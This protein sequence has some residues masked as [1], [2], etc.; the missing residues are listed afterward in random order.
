VR[1]S[2]LSLVARGMLVSEFS[3]RRNGVDVLNHLREYLPMV[4][5]SG[6]EIVTIQVTGK[7]T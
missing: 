2:G 5:I 7:F 6:V 1:D 4:L 3:L